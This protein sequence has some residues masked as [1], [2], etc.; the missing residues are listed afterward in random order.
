MNGGSSAPY[1]AL[2]PCVPLLSTLFNR[3]GNRRAFRLSG[4]GGGSFPLYGGTFARSYLVAPPHSLVEVF[5][6]VLGLFVDSFLEN[7]RILFCF[8]QS[9]GS[10]ES[11]NSLRIFTSPAAKQSL[12]ASDFWG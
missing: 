10:L 4:A 1:L 12:A 11:L 8:P 7:G 5:L 9:G 6:F 3:G 2:T